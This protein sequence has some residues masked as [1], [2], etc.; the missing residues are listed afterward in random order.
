MK[1]VSQMDIGELA[2]FVCSHLGNRGVKIVLTGGACVSIYSQNQYQSFDLDFVEQFS[3]KK[4]SLKEILKEIGFE[5]KGRHF[6]NP[7]TM[8]FLE[9]PPG[10]LS[11]G[12]EPVKTTEIL[13]FETGM[14]HLLSPTDCVK[15]RLA[16]YYHWNDMQCLEQAILVS[17]DKYL[18]YE[19]IERWSRKEGKFAEYE[20][21]R[22]KLSLT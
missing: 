7:E 10:P 2:A 15:D 5:E 4:Y 19:E 13:Q 22:E 18:D 16:G 12:D 17:R 8:F 6:T 11:V 21:F 14:L 9:F 1:P 3:A 20:K